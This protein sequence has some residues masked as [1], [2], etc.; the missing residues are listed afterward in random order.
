MYFLF[1]IIHIFL[2]FS[3]KF[4]C[5]TPIILPYITIYT[6]YIQMS[7]PF[8]SKIHIFLIILLLTLHLHYNLTFFL[9]FNF[10]TMKTIT[11]YVRWVGHHLKKHHRKYLFA[12]LLWWL[13]IKVVLFVFAGA[14]LLWLEKLTRAAPAFDCATQITDVSLS[15]C[16]AL[17]DLYTNTNG[18]NRTSNNWWL[19]TPAVCS[20]DGITCS[21]NHVQQ[22]I[23]NNNQLAWAIPA[24]ISDLTELYYLSLNQNQIS[25]LPESI[26]NLIN[27]NALY[28]N[29]NVLSDIPSSLGNMLYLNS[30]YLA[31]NQ[32]TSL[33]ASIGNLVYLSML[34]VNGN[35]LTSL[36]ASIGNLPVYAIYANDNQLTSLPESIGNLISMQFLSVCGNL[37]T[38]LPES[39]GNLTGL[40]TLYLNNNQL[41]SI[42]ESIGN[43]TGLTYLYVSQ[44]QLTFLPTNFGLLSGLQGADFTGNQLSSLP[45]SLI[46]LLRDH[47]YLVD[48]LNLAENTWLQWTDAPLFVS[49]T[50]ILWSLLISGNTYIWYSGDSWDG[51]FIGPRQTTNDKSASSWEIGLNDFVPLFTLEAGSD[52]ADLI[53]YTGTFAISVYVAG[54]IPGQAITLFRSN[55]NDWEIWEANTPD[56]S[57]ILDSDTY[58]TFQTDHLS[59]FALTTP[60]SEN[61]APINESNPST[62]QLGN[63]YTAPS[64]GSSYT[65]P[66]SQPNASTTGEQIKPKSRKCS[67]S[68]SSLLLKIKGLYSN[69]TESE[70][71]IK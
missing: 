31:N 12:S 29:D 27:L 21:N 17:V 51:T 20:W 68:R 50:D 40:K 65:T 39:I 19:T 13:T 6:Y 59:L 26:G 63:A 67:P 34:V 24:S 14:W 8:S 2:L 44:N 37:L 15:E 9:F 48:T 18:D 11:A 58:C 32:L 61:I 53:P 23:L 52:T 43:L 42:P 69:T 22:I 56:T 28:L 33:P 30:L 35:Q 60:P 1:I 47:P 70:C 7:I 62:P 45:A 36:P 5:F 3:L 46:I 38:S 41:I 49:W 64:R 16:Q 10:F 55:Y 54:W 4:F 25:S 57:C 66:V 71:T